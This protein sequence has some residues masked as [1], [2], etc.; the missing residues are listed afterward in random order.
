MSWSPDGKIL[1]SGSMDST[2]RLW[3]PKKGTPMG[4]PL[5]AHSQC[6]TSISWEPMHCNINCNR[7]ASASKDGTIR[8]W[9]ATLRKIIMV[10]SQHTGPIMCVKWGGDGFIYTASRDKTIKVWDAKDVNICILICSYGVQS[11]YFREK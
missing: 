10:L 8:I 7:F 6:I 3:E 5:R 1:A 4:D 2:I 11:N 9:D